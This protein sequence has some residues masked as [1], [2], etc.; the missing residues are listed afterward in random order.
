MKRG[1]S[2]DKWLLK[3]FIRK[4]PELF[5]CGSFSFLLYTI[6][7]ITL[8]PVLIGMISLIVLLMIF[9]YPVLGRIVAII[10]LTTGLYFL[11]AA[12]SEYRE[13]IDGDQQTTTLLENRLFVFGGN[14]L[15]GTI[16]VVKFSSKHFTAP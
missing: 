4:L 2:S 13:F 12:F 10:V 16:M 1:V 8:G 9:P 14:I 7:N 3:S 11:L 6:G 15:A 5:L